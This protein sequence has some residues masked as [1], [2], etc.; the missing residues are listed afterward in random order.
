MSRR[1]LLAAVR[2]PLLYLATFLVASLVYFSVVNEFFASVSNFKTIGAGAAGLG[3]VAICVTLALAVGAID[4]SVAGNIALCGVVG[5]WLSQH[6]PGGLAIVAV[7]LV[8]LLV[9]VVNGSIIT[10]FNVNPFIMTLAA[11]GSL[12]GLSFVMGGSS[13]G[14]EVQ[15]SALMWLG[16][17]SIAGLPVPLIL[18]AVVTA[19]AAFVLRSLPFGRNLLAVGGNVEAG[20][21]AGLPVARLQV[22]GYMIS[23]FGAGLGGLLLAARSGAGLPQAASSQ[24]L[25]IFSAVILGGTSLWGGRAS[26]IGS[27]LGILLINVLY[28]GLTLEQVSSYWQTILQGVLL[29]L[30]VALVKQKELGFDLTRLLRGGGGKPVP[31]AEP[32][33]VAGRPS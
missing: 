5:A 2:S 22:A 28:D 1:L 19:V 18:L 21:L 29:I 26:V 12:R 30:A 23:A 11:A 32:A 33:P 10:R 17:G 4:F 9:G 16:Q 7:L 14:M 15:S 8:A 24:E 3:V 31:P 6:V 27:L 25:L 13:A 20:R